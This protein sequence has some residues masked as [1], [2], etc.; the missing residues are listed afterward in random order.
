M[1]NRS[2]TCASARQTTRRPTPTRR[3]LQ[4][5]CWTVSGPR[6]ALAG[7]LSPALIRIRRGMVSLEEHRQP[8]V[9]ASNA[10]AAAPPTS[11]NVPG[12]AELAARGT[13]R[14]EGTID[15]R[16]EDRSGTPCS[17]PAPLP[18]RECQSVVTDLGP[19]Q[20]ALAF[21]RRGTDAHR[22]RGCAPVVA[23]GACTKGTAIANLLPRPGPFRRPPYQA[24][25][26]R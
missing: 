2:R 6:E 19:T 9:S 7:G 12:V 18:R 16:E 1:V 14:A 26:R 21:H 5:P 10:K 15:P 3:S 11:N 25:M 8:A 17:A 23:T 20:R 24:D 4:R 13:R 22:G